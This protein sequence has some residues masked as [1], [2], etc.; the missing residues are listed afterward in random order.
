MNRKISI[1][2]LIAFNFLSP[3]L[4]G[5]N[6]SR[7][8]VPFKIDIPTYQ[9]SDL[10][11]RLQLS[12]WPDEIADSGWGYGAN[13]AY[14]KNICHYWQKEFD[15]KKQENKLNTLK[16]YQVKIDDHLIHFIYEKGKGKSSTPLVLLHGWPGSF[17]Q[18]LKIIPLLTEPDSTGHSFDVI[19]PSLPGYGFSSRPH[20]RG[21]NVYLM[22]Q[23]LHRLIKEKLN[24]SKVMLRGSDIGAGVAREWALSFPEDVIGLHLSGSN[25]YVYQ[26]PS[27]LTEAEKSFIQ[28]GQEF[29]QKEGAYA[30][31]QSSKP[32]TL[33]Y[34]LNDSP[35]GLAAWILEKFA[36]WSDNAGNLE[37][38]FTKDELLTNISIYWFTETIG[39]SVRVYFES[40][41]SWS[42]NGMNKV[43]TPT[44]FMMLEK[45]IAVGP[46]EW[47]DRSYNIIHWH[48]HPSGGHFGEWEEPNVIANDLQLFYKEI[49]KH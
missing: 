44:G 24:I 15:W 43:K 23:L 41:H 19:V 8:I 38:K 1:G 17:W 6:W 13:L 10:N 21:M 39:S 34:A 42:P 9:L 45:D 2:V 46:R 28:K 11:A 14:I 20:H 3:A 49:S 36:A 47:E 12:R 40:A 31:E 5:Q 16:Q 26:V 7:D 27:D 37:T 29:F 25:P 4:Y 30:M 48:T 18:M 33:S 32:Q 22:A 35:I